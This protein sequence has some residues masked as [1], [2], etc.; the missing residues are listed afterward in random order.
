LSAEPNGWKEANGRIL[1]LL[2]VVKARTAANAKLAKISP[3]P[4]YP[5]K[6]HAENALT[7]PAQKPAPSGN[8]LL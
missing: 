8:V 2:K 6:F 5:R 3:T 1:S 4:K 7:A